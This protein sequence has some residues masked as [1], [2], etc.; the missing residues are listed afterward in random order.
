MDA[1]DPELSMTV[2]L[3]NT[4]ALHTAAAQ[5]HVEVVTFLL[6]R[7]SSLAPIAKS[8]GKTALHSAA[9]HGYL[10]VV[11]ALLSK[12]PGLATRTDKK[13]QTALHM[14]VKG[15]NVELVDEL[16]KSDP[17]LINMID[18]KGCTALHIA[19]RKGRLQVRKLSS[20]F[21]IMQEVIF[22]SFPNLIEIERKRRRQGLNSEDM[23]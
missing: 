15:Q 7:G 9:R 19:T 23:I 8:N 5:G 20:C 12:E 13:G 22:F 4:T 1:I 6:E 18:T 11:S 14:T 10:E 16:V 17:S 21:P 3:S 2:D